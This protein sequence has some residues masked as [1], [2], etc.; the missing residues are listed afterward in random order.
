MLQKGKAFVIFNLN[1]P[2]ER[3]IDKAL[4]TVSE[5]EDLVISDS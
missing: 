2:T 3:N 1:P 5:Q 4:K